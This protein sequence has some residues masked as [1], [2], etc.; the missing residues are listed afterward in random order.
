M[1]LR[2][3]EKLSMMILKILIIYTINKYF[4]IKI[5]PGKFKLGLTYPGLVLSNKTAGAI[6]K[7]FNSIEK[8][9]GFNGKDFNLLFDL[10]FI[11]PYFHGF[12]L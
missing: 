11:T 12:T 4:W 5:I 2:N 3:E 1:S 10:F 9:P 8:I 6:G 7:E